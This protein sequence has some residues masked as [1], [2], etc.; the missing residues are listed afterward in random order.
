MWVGGAGDLGRSGRPLS[1]GAAGVPRRSKS[2]SSP[3]SG[4]WHLPPLTLLQHC[5]LPHPLTPAHPE[6]LVFSA[7]CLRALWLQGLP[8]FL[9]CHPSLGPLPSL[10]IQP[11][12]KLWAVPGGLEIIDTLR[13]FS[14]YHPYQ[15][16]CS[17]RSTIHFTLQAS[18]PILVPALPP[19]RRKGYGKQLALASPRLGIWGSYCLLEPT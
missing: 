8:G 18:L 19:G 3:C 12:P 1:A 5:P 6:A 11:G 15:L 16:S 10:Q 13:G 7:L 9:L 17:T 14:S 4:S 2:P